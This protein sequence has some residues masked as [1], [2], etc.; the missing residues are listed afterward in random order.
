MKLYMQFNNFPP[1]LINICSFKHLLA[2]Y[3]PIINI[4]NQLQYEGYLKVPR[5]KKECYLKVLWL[6][7]DAALGL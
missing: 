1:L 7:S 2:T 6:S 5:K 4:Y 3:D